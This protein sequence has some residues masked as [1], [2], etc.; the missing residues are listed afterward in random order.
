VGYPAF[1]ELSGALL[2]AIGLAMLGYA[3]LYPVRFHWH[4]AQGFAKAVHRVLSG[5]NKEARDQLAL[6]LEGH[7]NIQRIARAGI[8]KKGFKGEATQR[9]GA[10]IRRRLGVPGGTRE[11]LVH[12]ASDNYV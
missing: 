7:G 5:N 9:S 1:W 8:N 11:S 12:R 3:H 10:I 6:E 2:G 4:N